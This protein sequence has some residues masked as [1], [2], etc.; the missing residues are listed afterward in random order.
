MTLQ[1]SALPAWRKL[2]R[3]CWYSKLCCEYV[4]PS[5]LI[6]WLPYNITGT[7]ANGVDYTVWIWHSY[8]SSRRYVSVNI[9]VALLMIIS[10]KEAETLV[11]TLTNV[12]GDPD[13]KALAPADLTAQTN[14]IMIL[15][16]F[17][18]FSLAQASMKML[19]Q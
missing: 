6:L 17:L 11:L 3:R 10:L 16:L 18:Y 4:K 13:I 15:R 14:L 9:P 12:A 19:V 2:Q 8:Y 5:V 7:A 1:Q